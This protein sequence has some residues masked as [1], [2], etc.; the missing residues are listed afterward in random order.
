VPQ[1]LWPPS[2]QELVANGD[3]EEAALAPWKVTG[4]AALDAGVIYSGEQSLSLS[5]SPAGLGVASQLLTIPADATEATLF[6]AL[7]IISE[8]PDFGS[9]PQDPFDDHLRVDFRSLSGETLVTLLRAGN[10]SD[11]GLNVPWDEYLYRLTPED[12][13][14]L[15]GEG[16]V[17]LYFAADNND[18]PEVTSFHVDQVRFCAGWGGMAPRL[19]VPLVTG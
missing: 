19:Y 11:G 2:C 1:P 15:R 17:L 14:L 6:F 9:D 3:F 4:E 18:D 5:G 13:Q 16:T 7:R 10:T 8:D 12:M